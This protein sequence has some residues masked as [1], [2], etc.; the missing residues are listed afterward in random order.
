MS[1]FVIYRDHAGEYHWHLLT[2][3]NRRIAHSGEGYESESDCIEAIS[4]VKRIASIAEAIDPSVEEVEK[5]E[6]WEPFN[7]LR[8]LSFPLV[9]PGLSQP[10]SGSLTAGA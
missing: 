9:I 2:S 8:G 5:E 6:A 1:A 4:L 3:T 10:G 7:A